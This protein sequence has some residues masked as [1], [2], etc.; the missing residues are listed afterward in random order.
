MAHARACARLPASSARSPS[1]QWYWAITGS[2]LR[3]T[4]FASQ[5]WASRLPVG[6]TGRSAFGN[7]MTR[8]QIGARVEGLSSAPHTLHDGDF[9][10]TWR[11]SDENIRFVLQA[12]EVL[13]E[14]ARAGVSSRV[15]DTGLGLSI[16]RD[17]S[18]RTRY[19]FRSACSL[20]GLTTE[21]LDESTVI[22]HC[23]AHLAHFKCPKRVIFTD[24]LPRNPSG[25]ILK[26]DLRARYEHTTLQVNNN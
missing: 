17:K 14:F 9:L 16:F 20:L 19:A 6:E 8:D 26:R 2:R 15:F 7:G 3:P 10:L 22:A 13:E 5:G 18:T 21:E 12:A 24:S 23:T 25:K 11:Q 4:V 1:S